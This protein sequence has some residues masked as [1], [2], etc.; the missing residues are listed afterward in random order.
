MQD[1]TDRGSLP[2]SVTLSTLIEAHVPF[3]SGLNIRTVGLQPPFQSP[4]RGHY[5]ASVCQCLTLHEAP[6]RR[7]LRAAAYIQLQPLLATL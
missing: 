7:T 3:I 4:R 2:S 1:D 5:V 6:Q